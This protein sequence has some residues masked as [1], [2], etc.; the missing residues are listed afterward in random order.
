[1][2]QSKFSVNESDIPIITDQ[3]VGMDDALE[4]DKYYVLRQLPRKMI[5]PKRR[6]LFINTR[7]GRGAGRSL[8][9]MRWI[10]ECYLDPRPSAGEQ[11][12]TSPS[13][14]EKL[15]QCCSRLLNEIESSP[16]SRAGVQRWR[17]DEKS[18]CDKPH[19]QCFS[20]TPT[21]SSFSSTATVTE[22]QITVKHQDSTC[23]SS[24]SSSV[25]SSQPTENRPSDPKSFELKDL[26]AYGSAVPPLTG[27]SLTSIHSPIEKFL[28]CKRPETSVT[29][30]NLFSEKVPEMSVSFWDERRKELASVSNSSKQNGRD[31][32]PATQFRAEE[33]STKDEVSGKRSRRMK[34]TTSPN[35][36]LM[37]SRHTALKRSLPECRSSPFVETN[38]TPSDLNSHSEPATEASHSLTLDTHILDETTAMTHLILLITLLNQLSQGTVPDNFQIMS[39]VTDPNSAKGTVNSENPSELVAAS[40]SSHVQS[41]VTSSLPP[42]SI[43]SELLHLLAAPSNPSPN[44]TTFQNS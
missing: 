38:D 4:A 13:P 9:R 15:I 31:S 14:L 12:F 8:H 11:L 34:S 29:D 30:T 39:G 23:F 10:S 1:M 21:H 26:A 44:D 35:S 16:P 6:N 5:T 36:V 3:S 41:P 2:D 28:S 27:N 37:D 40:R 24:L 7:K 25:C 43:L 32:L 33:P 18:D 42:P 19:E 20:Q 22:N 17:R